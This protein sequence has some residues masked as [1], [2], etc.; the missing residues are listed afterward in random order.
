MSWHVEFEEESGDIAKFKYSISDTGCGC[1]ATTYYRSV[2]IRKEVYTNNISE[3]DLQ[4]VIEDL[5][6]SLT[7]ALALRDLLKELPTL[8]KEP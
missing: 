4:K 8:Y 7:N 2:D 1:C 5:N 6:T 3:K